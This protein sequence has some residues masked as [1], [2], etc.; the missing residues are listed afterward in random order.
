MSPPGGVLGATER[1]GGIRR[2]SI[3][4]VSRR[5][6]CAVV[7]YADRRNAELLK[8]VF[9]ADLP[10]AVLPCVWYHIILP[11]LA[12][13]AAVFCGAI[14]ALVLDEANPPMGTPIMF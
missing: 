5:M 12:L 1:G 6:F 11:L 7:S 9:S 10:S 4:S 13:G 2:G 14:P 3:I 8:S